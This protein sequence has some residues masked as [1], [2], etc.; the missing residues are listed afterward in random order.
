MASEE[1]RDYVCDRYYEYFKY[2]VENNIEFQAEL[3]RLYNIH[4]QYG[5]LRLFCW[6]YPKRCHAEVI[7]N[8]LENIWKTVKFSL[9][10]CK[11]MI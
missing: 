6:C 8:Y 2:E 5:K 1:V 4:K 3:K 7:K 9:Q 10:I 11:Y